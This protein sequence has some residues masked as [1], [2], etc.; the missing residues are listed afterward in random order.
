MTP[1]TITIT[2]DERGSCDMFIGHRSTG[3][4]SFGEMLEQVVALC[5]PEI[6]RPRY[7]MYTWQE[8]AE[9][10][11]GRHGIQAQHKRSMA[12]ARSFRGEAWA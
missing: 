4:L 11:F 8:H 1:R 10:L 5:H 7:P 6:D 9:G 12:A 2:V 3:A